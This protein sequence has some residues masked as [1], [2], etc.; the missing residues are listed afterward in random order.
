VA[1]LSFLFGRPRSPDP[2][3][4]E[5]FLSRQAAFVAQKTVLDY[6]RVKSGSNEKKV[7]ADPDFVAALLHCRWQVFLAALADLAGLA[8]AWLRPHCPGQEAALAA[9][10]AAWHAGALAAQEIPQAER[11]SAAAAQRAIAGHLAQLQAAPPSP[12]HRRALLAEAP[13]FDT[14]PI[15]AEQRRGEGLAIRG[16]LRF[17]I[18]S[19]Q[20][21]ME[22]GFDPAGLCAA[23]LRQPGV[24]SGAEGPRA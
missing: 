21:E 5:E 23:L 14:L 24:G 12:A 11:E 7:F 19:A 3:A 22:R 2:A 9:R 13:L 15:H 16:A 17:H 4:F 10:L 20:Q 6:C 8:E 1:L 18:V